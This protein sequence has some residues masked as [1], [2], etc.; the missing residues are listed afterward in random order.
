MSAVVNAV[1]CRET[2]LPRCVEGVGSLGSDVLALRGGSP[3]VLKAMIEE[4]GTEFRKG[5]Y[6]LTAGIAVF[7]AP[8][9]A[10][11]FTSEDVSEL[12]KAL[13]L[14][15]GLAVVSM[16]STTARTDDQTKS[17]DP[18]ESFLIGERA[19]RFLRIQSGQGR[20]A[21]LADLGTQPPDLAV[22][23]EH[24]HYDPKKVE[25]CRAAGIRELWELATGAAP[26]APRILDL[27]A[28]GGA[29]P[30]VASRILQGVI[31]DQLPAAV[32][33]LR[34]IGGLVVFARQME[35]GKPVVESLLATAGVR[36]TL[37]RRGDR[38]PG[39]NPG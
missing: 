20:E 32:A 12:I 36:E 30:V 17:M 19:T 38:S 23:V 11:E 28:Q 10:H 35:R 3:R 27:Q 25:V 26:R 18:D 14:S 9:S 22:E 4:L 5:W 33:E 1:H 34:N 2:I 37:E 13:C 15:S 7:M 29:R 39:S 6:D 24:T 31:A 21:A 16:R 8:S